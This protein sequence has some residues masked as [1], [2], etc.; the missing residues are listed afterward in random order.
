MCSTV[1]FVESL[2][3]RRREENER[4][5]NWKKEKREDENKTRKR[6][7]R[8]LSQKAFNFALQR[9]KATA[10][11]EAFD[12]STTACRVKKVEKKENVENAKNSNGR[13]PPD[14]K[15]I[16]NSVIGESIHHPHHPTTIPAPRCR[17]GR[18]G[19][20]AASAING[21]LPWLEQIQH[22]LGH[23]IQSNSL[24]NRRG[25]EMKAC[26]GCGLRR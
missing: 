18:C 6:V 17:G 23:F 15:L 8:I 22:A 14:L 5:R 4:I 10:N 12:V 13:K 21:P 9:L 24:F 26:T 25:E 19:D 2:E 3:T 7:Q 20:C 1:V 11:T 16:A